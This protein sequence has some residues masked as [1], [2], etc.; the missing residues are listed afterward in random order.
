M[1]FK[2]QFSG[3]SDHI[4]PGPAAIVRYQ[5][6][7]FQTAYFQLFIHFFVTFFYLGTS[8]VESGM[9]TEDFYPQH[10]VPL[11][12]DIPSNYVA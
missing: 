3:G 11:Y 7:L 10:S 5:F 12:S 4:T 8:F 2:W 9:K 1:T 6:T